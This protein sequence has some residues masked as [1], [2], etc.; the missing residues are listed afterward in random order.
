MIVRPPLHI[1]MDG[2]LPGATGAL[3]ISVPHGKLSLVVG[4]P[5]SGKSTIRRAVEQA[6]EQQYTLLDQLRGTAALSTALEVSGPARVIN[7]LPYR[8]VD[9][10]TQFSFGLTIA[11]VLSSTTATQVE[12]TGSCPA[13]GS[14]ATAAFSFATYA[15]WLI[16][17]NTGAPVSISRTFLFDEP[18]SYNSPDSLFDWLNE[19]ATTGR[20]R[21]RLDDI[22]LD[23]D[24]PAETEGAFPVTVHEALE[25]IIDRIVLSEEQQQRLCTALGEAVTT[26]TPAT[27]RGEKHFLLLPGATAFCQQCGTTFRSSTAIPASLRLDEAL[28]GSPAALTLLQQADF[29]S[30]LRTASLTQMTASLSPTAFQFLQLLAVVVRQESQKLVLIDHSPV[31]SFDLHL[32]AMEYFIKL[33]V[34]RENT[35]LFFAPCVPASLPEGSEVFRLPAKRP[36]PPL[37]GTPVPKIQF[38]GYGVFLLDEYETAYQRLALEA[39]LYA[40]RSETSLLTRLEEHAGS[41]TIP[42]QYHSLQLAASDRN[43]TVLSLPGLQK[44]LTSLFEKLPA[45]R[46]YGLSGSDFAKVLSGDDAN[47][48]PDSIRYRGYS[49]TELVSHSVAAAYDLLQ[50]I[51]AC[52]MPLQALAAAGLEQ[53][54]LDRELPALSQTEQLGFSLARLA[55]RL[56]R[57]SVVVVPDFSHLIPPAA[58]AHL[59]ESLSE[60]CVRRSVTILVSARQTVL[61]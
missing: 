46:K 51:P 54:P 37:I 39:R 1:E 11:D 3:N 30:E 41:S 27:V 31:S 23:L 57:N 56:K 24:D 17:L 61:Q 8:V 18:H 42:V 43:R 22:N 20:S 48:L 29:P 14:T 53:L 34:E 28:T 45:A 5:G 12:Y 4:D 50:H 13:C 9:G 60:V 10:A 35:L 16:N 15:A 21:L 19:R 7:A 40:V 58:L 6:I 59:I 47:S 52:A 49:V 26:D 2:T 32:R 55:L 25:V 44:G 33:A 38:E 36:V